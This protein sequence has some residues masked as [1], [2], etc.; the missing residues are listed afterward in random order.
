LA[1]NVSEAAAY[2]RNF[3]KETSGLEHFSIAV[4]LFQI[5]LVLTPHFGI[6]LNC[7]AAKVMFDT[8]VTQPSSET[9]P[10]KTNCN[11]ILAVDFL[12]RLYLEIGLYMAD[13][14]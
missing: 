2:Y 6:K 14:L 3:L 8:A 11:R 7:C 1:G 12:A 4:A 9:N 5:N 13:D 10:H